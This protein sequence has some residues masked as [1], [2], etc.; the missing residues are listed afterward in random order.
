MFKIV[1]RHAPS[2]VL[3]I[4]ENIIFDLWRQV[5]PGGKRI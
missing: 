4:A 2:D 5:K 3:W 1:V